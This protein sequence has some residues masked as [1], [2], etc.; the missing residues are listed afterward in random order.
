MMKYQNTFAEDMA[1]KW[2][3]G[4]RE[5]VRRVIRGSIDKKQAAYIAA[6]VATLVSNPAEFVEFIHP[7]AN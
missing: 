5:E 3:A 6:H 4:S 2:E 1:K 7:D